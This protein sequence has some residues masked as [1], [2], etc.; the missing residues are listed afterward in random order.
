M[1][2]HV[3]GLPHTQTTEEFT[4]CAFTQKAL[5]LC[6][7]MTRRGHE[8]I[9]YGVE[10]S[11][12]ECTKNVSVMPASVWKQ[13]VGGHPGRNF[14]NIEMGGK[15]AP[16]HAMFAKN[17]HDGL[18]KN[19]GDPY[20]EI[21]CQ[22]WGGAQCTACEGIPQYMVESG[23]G[24]PNSWA[25]WRVYE[26]YAWMHMHLGRDN[27]FG[28]R[29]WYWAVIPNAFPVENFTPVAKRGE[30][31]LF[32]GRL[33]EDKGVGIA[34]DVA[35]RVGRKITIVG[36]GN[37]GPYMH[38]NPHVSYLPPVGVEERRTL[39]AEAHAVMCI[40]QFVE[41]FCGVN[42][43]AQMSGTPVIASD[44][45]VFSETILHGVTGWRGRTI[46]Q[47]VWAA[48]NIDKIDGRVCAQWARDNFSLERVA[49]MYEEFFQQVLNVRDHGGRKVVGMT[50]FYEPHPGR[51]QLDWLLR[52]YPQA[53]AEVTIDLHRP[54]EAPA[55]VPMLAAAPVVVDPAQAWRK[56]QVF[57]RAY[58]GLDWSALWDEEIA[59]QGTYFRLM[60]IGDR[61]DF[62][63]RQILDVGCGPVSRLLRTKHGPSRGVD[64][65]PVSGDT[66]AR[67]E[68]AGV[69]L[70][71]VPAEEMPTDRKFD[72]V[73]IY[74]CLQHVRDPSIVLQRALSVASDDV[75]IFEWLNVPVDQGHPHR[76]TESIF[77]A[78]FG[79]GWRRVSWRIGD[80]NEA[81][82]ASGRYI[83]IHAKRIGS[84]QPR[85]LAAAPRAE[86]D[87]PQV[88][89]KYFLELGSADWDTL[90]ET[91]GADPGWRGVTVDA[92][93]DLLDRLPTRSNVE[94]ISAVVVV[95]SPAPATVPFYYVPG[96]I[97]TGRGFPGWLHGCGSVHRDHA[98]LSL[99]SDKAVVVKDV[100]AVGLR[101][102]VARVPDVADLHTVKTDLEGDDF[103]VVMGLLDL[104]VRPTTLEF[105][106]VHMSAADRSALLSRLSMEGYDRVERSGDS[107]ITRRFYKNQKN[108]AGSGAT[109]GAV[110][111]PTAHL[112]AP[113][114]VDPVVVSLPRMGASIPKILHHIWIGSSFPAEL[115]A[116]RHSWL[117]H[118]PDWTMM[119]WRG[120]EPVE[121]RVATVLKNDRYS[122]VVK[123][124]VLR[125]YALAKMGGLYVD[126][127]F[128]CL[129]PMGKLLAPGGFHCGFEA[130]QVLSSALMACP[131][132]DGFVRSLLDA[133]LL[134]LQLVSPPFV[135]R[136]PDLVTGPRLLT[137][138]GMTASITR[139]AREVFYPVRGY[140]RERLSEPPPT[141]SYARHHWAG[142]TSKG[143]L[144]AQR[145]VMSEAMEARVIAGIDDALVGWR[146]DDTVMLPAPPPTY[147]SP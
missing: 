29:K 129:K 85:M 33:N 120:E 96:E 131:A 15:M 49:P 108:G 62:G 93:A 119:F 47:F 50:G 24:Y 146:D 147:A 84:D 44:Y 123:S 79:E 51:T 139:H 60:G 28:G 3:L 75:R 6:R 115:H 110:D 67:Y 132:G 90:H 100:P 127:D 12:P 27:L 125:F 58:W 124:D 97:V 122:P 63:D 25:E 18:V 130:E 8:V 145:V 22:P 117:K 94:K 133:A 23:I 53:A 68:A 111:R 54:H 128:E 82:G 103:A 80:V 39:L 9:H 142:G 126:T 134:R 107:L 57:E 91:L 70:V 101:D 71:G 137:E 138:L 11:N 92:R 143:W 17:M 2:I 89:L 112:T 7:M 114:R 65:L 34:I 140:E 87:K 88:R 74:N 20:T 38:D 78:A 141:G 31:L 61:E 81:T 102:L 42:V 73:W 16:Y 1:R 4:T 98:I 116:F 43:E 118:H 135:N 37:P 64:P 76:L 72:E 21:V 113:L 35:K 99:F 10:G 32:L 104:G 109:H 105:E 14:Y 19:T 46:E 83:A 13:F 95:E 56:A 66:K 86:V 69:E 36:Q 55:P 41:P 52:K 144:G 121:D 136:R 59:K 77:L 30:D 45:G 48:K 26:S 106:D 40:T 5:N